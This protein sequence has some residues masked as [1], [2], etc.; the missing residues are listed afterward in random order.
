[1]EQIEICM[2]G[3]FSLRCADRILSDT[4]R[5]RK[6][7]QLLAYLICHRGKAVTPKK[8]IGLF[9]NE[10]T[11]SPENA[12]R[13][14]F[15]RIRSQLDTLFPGAGKQL[16]LNTDAGYC[17]N[18]RIEITV[19]CERFDSLC[20]QQTAS[21]EERLENLLEALSLY[22][23]DFLEKQSSEIWVIPISAHY[24]NMYIQASLEAARLLSQRGEHSSAAHIC[25]KAISADPYHEEVHQLLI[26]ELAASGK[27]E[28]AVRVYDQLSQ[29]LFADFGILPS[30]Q[31][32]AVYRAAVHNPRQSSLTM[33][34]ILEQI[35]EHTQIEG[36]MQL[37]YD[38]FR[39]LCQV[40]CRSIERYGRSTHIA[41]IS[42]EPGQK[43][44][45]TRR[46]IH[47]IMDQLEPQLHIYLHRG[48]VFSR[49]S[50]NQYILMLPKVN[51][52]DSCMVCRNILDGFYREHPLV[53]AT[54]HYVVHPLCPDIQ[55]P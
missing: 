49:C 19:D 27:E 37:D 35:Q 17:W 51:Y 7:W 45:L 42:V 41:L 53:T 39:V 16:I 40:E 24:H 55:V 52:E 31:T 36:P 32:R 14:S 43:H 15:H 4:G 12:V 50:G 33:D 13:I 23:G 11:G 30:D 34:M 20:M 46:S 25:R 1:V 18:D 44:T 38:Y 6:S 5:S 2:L 48:D 9:W 10:D 47:R 54:V 22:K 29:R 3:E 26:R 8:L 28:E 21:P